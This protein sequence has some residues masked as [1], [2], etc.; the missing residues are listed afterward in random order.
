MDS[1]QIINALSEAI[2]I[3]TTAR[4]QLGNAPTELWIIPD[5]AIRHLGKQ[6]N[7]ELGR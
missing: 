5:H 6:I 1:I 7:A 2:Q 4:K 3:L